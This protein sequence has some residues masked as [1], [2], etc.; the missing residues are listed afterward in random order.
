MYIRIGPTLPGFTASLCVNGPP[1]ATPG[2][3]EHRDPRTVP[4][5][6]ALSPIT[7]VPLSLSLCTAQMSWLGW[8]LV[9]LVAFYGLSPPIAGTSFATA[10]I[11]ATSLHVWV[12]FDAARLCGRLKPDEYMKGVVFFYADLLSIVAV[13]LVCA[14]CAAACS[15]ADA[16][17]GVGADCAYGSTAVCCLDDGSGAAGEADGEA[18]TQSV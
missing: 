16:S 6:A 8:L 13:C 14:W 1:L 2:R 10:C 3:G 11:F 15:G 12:S 17:A 4:R 5:R 7:H 9:A 18:P